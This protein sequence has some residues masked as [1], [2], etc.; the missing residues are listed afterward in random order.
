MIAIITNIL[1]VFL[2]SSVLHDTQLSAVTRINVILMSVAVVI[3]VSHYCSFIFL[4]IYLFPIEQGMVRVLCSSFSRRE[5]PLGTI[6][7]FKDV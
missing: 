6:G 1:L 7:Q 3:D 5:L 2:L 4:L